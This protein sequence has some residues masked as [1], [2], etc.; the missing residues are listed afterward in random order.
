MLIVSF[1]PSSSESL[2]ASSDLDARASV[3]GVS[4]SR[5]VI[6]MAKN[7]GDVEHKFFSF[8]LASDYL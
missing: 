7:R 5:V 6:A 3:S 2:M 8:R 1:S 4:I